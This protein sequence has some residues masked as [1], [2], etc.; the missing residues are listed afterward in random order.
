MA[1]A[2]NRYAAPARRNGIAASLANPCFRTKSVRAKAGKGSYRRTDKHKAV[3][4]Y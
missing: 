3:H 1:A 2:S 4:A